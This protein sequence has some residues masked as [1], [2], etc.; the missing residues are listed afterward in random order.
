MRTWK[1]QE[2]KPLEAD[3]G[4]VGKF[5]NVSLQQWES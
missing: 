2:Q 4:E 5:S 1:L 3:S